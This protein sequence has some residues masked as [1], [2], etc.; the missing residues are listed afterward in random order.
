M[1]LTGVAERVTVPAYVMGGSKDAI[2]PPEAAARMADEISGPVTFN[3]I[4]GGN[5][6]SSNKAYLYRPQSADWMAEQLGA[7]GG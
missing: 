1:N 7:A 5:H 6:V 4:E 2:V 3:M